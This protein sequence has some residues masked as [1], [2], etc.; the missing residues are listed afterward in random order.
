[1]FNNRITT[2]DLILNYYKNP[3]AKPLQVSFIAVLCLNWMQYGKQS[4]LR[5]RVPSVLCKLT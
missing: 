4:L 3:K 1:M 2:S 5:G